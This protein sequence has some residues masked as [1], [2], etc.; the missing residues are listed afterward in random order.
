MIRRTA[1][2]KGGRS[3]P[4]RR[5]LRPPFFSAPQPRYEALTTRSSPSTGWAA[6]LARG[7][8]PRRVL[9]GPA[10]QPRVE[11]GKHDVR[12]D[13]VSRNRKHVFVVLR[14]HLRVG[15][16]VQLVQVPRHAGRSDGDGD[17]L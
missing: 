9:I 3:P 13:V 12:V 2:T 8:N 11:L 7:P 10:C 14:V 16:Q 5:R 6:R 4:D 1:I 15:Q 17:T